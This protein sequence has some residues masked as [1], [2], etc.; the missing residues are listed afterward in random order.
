MHRSGF[1]AR[2]GAAGDPVLWAARADAVSSAFGPYLVLHG[3]GVWPVEGGGEGFLVGW[4]E[5]TVAV[6]GHRDRRVPEVD[7]C[8]FGAGSLGYEQRRSWMRRPW[9]RP[10][11]SSAGFQILRRKLELRSGKTFCGG[12]DQC[13]R[14]VWDLLD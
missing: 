7:V 13:I 8:R 10:A 11:R 1:D 14:F 3:L 9:G 12:E 4:E 6:H 5:V 2:P